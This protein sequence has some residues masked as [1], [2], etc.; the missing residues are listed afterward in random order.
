MVSP[1][2][3]LVSSGL[4]VSRLLFDLKLCGELVG[5]FSGCLEPSAIA[6][7][8]TDGLVEQ[9]GC[10]FAR[11]WLVEPDRAGLRLVASSGLYTRLDGSFARV[12]MGAFKVGKIA[13]HGIPFLSNCL[14]EEGWVKDRDWAVENKI[15]GF[16]GLPLTMESRSI[17]VLA[18]FS[19]E[20]MAGEFL[21][22]LQIL[23][24]SVANALAG[25]M[26]HQALVG[27]GGRRAEN[28]SERLAGLLGAQRLSLLGMER[29]IPLPVSQLF[30]RT[31]E[32]LAALS[33]HYCRLMYEDDAVVLEAMLAVTALNLGTP[34]AGFEEISADAARMNGDCEVSVGDN[35]RVMRVRLW[36]PLA[37]EPA[38]DEMG[39]D[40]M[41]I[42]GIEKKKSPLSGREHEVIE[43]LVQGLRDREIAERL[44][45]SER[46][47][48]FHVKNMLEKLG[49]KTRVQGVFEAMKQGWLG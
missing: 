14:A 38:T 23:S 28:L 1:A 12:P 11:I 39:M 4:D 40:G 34:P 41:E 21:E 37:S 17:G 46:T 22:V 16:A 24:V 5:R 47:V 49:V 13:E 19:Q 8:V 27:A 42:D 29:G 9:F 31:G 18:V 43:L 44:Y 30:V 2:S 35:R 33:C 25:A 15:L 36:V 48:K 26:K 20:P 45:I 7:C 3:S 10:V 32:R 6:A